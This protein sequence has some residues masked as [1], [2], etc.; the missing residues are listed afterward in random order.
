MLA[1]LTLGLQ[2]CNQSRQGRTEETRQFLNFSKT[3]HE[4]KARKSLVLILSELRC[5][6]QITCRPI[7]NTEAMGSKCHDQYL[8][9]VH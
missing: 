1:P 4:V 8:K 2:S 3:Q 9:L 5:F 7:K 6:R